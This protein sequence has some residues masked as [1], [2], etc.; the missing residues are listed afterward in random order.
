MTF[1]V[2]HLTASFFAWLF[3]LS[4][5]RWRWSVLVEAFLAI[6][7]SALMLG[8]T[9]K[10]TSG[11]LWRSVLS[12]TVFSLFLTLNG[13]HLFGLPLCSVS[14]NVHVSVCFDPC[15][16]KPSGFVLCVISRLH[17]VTSLLMGESK[18]VGAGVIRWY[19]SSW[20]L[21]FALV[22][23]VTVCSL[24]IEICE[25]SSETDIE[26]SSDG[27]WHPIELSDSE[28]V[29]TFICISFTLLCLSLFLCSY[30]LPFLL[31]A[32]PLCLSSTYVYRHYCRQSK[33][34]SSR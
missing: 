27:N 18:D 17:S 10:W 1:F 7:S 31:R 11:Q 5:A 23:L 6:I 26:F 32:K 2:W 9:C 12:I 22:G 29:F 13:V 21:F 4:W 14:V 30:I 25:Q 33:S 28:Y 15:P 16:E 34:Q 24:L 20:L 3:P 8:H 19:W